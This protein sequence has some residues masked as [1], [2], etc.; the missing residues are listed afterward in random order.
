[1]RSKYY[2]IRL[3]YASKSLFVIILLFVLLNLA[4]NFIFKA[5]HTPI[6]RWDLYSHQIPQQQAYSFLEVQYNGGQVLLFPHTW[7]EP[8]KLFFTN[9][10]TYF[11]AMRRN[12]DTDPLKHYIDN[13]NSNHPSFQKLLPALKFYNDSSEVKEF[14]VWYKKYLEQYIKKS[15]YE[16]EVYEIKIGYQKDGCIKKLS[17]TLIYKLL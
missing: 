14:P 12:N 16:I 6:F 4:A 13:W 7:E 10:L 15:V 17:S 9:T 1:M 8:G 2:F 11:I 5:E 3:F